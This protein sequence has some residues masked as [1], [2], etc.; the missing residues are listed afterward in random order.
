[1]QIETIEGVS[2]CEKIA[3]VLGL[4]GIFI[5]PGDLS[6]RLKHAP[7]C[8]FYLDE[9]VRRRRRPQKARQCLARDTQHHRELA[10]MGAQLAN[11]GSEYFEIVNELESTDRD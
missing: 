2:N 7:N 1:M 8:G 10:A 4:D 5:G 11:H 9:A 3:A 6:L